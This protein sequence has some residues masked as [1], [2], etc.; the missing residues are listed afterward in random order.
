MLA[1]SESIGATVV[2]CTSPSSCKTVVAF[3][4]SLP[5]VTSPLPVPI[6]A[7]CGASEPCPEA[8]EPPSTA[9]GVSK[10]EPRRRR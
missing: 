4:V 2:G 3:V 8:N 5:A 7:I 10:R 9:E 6:V 1:T